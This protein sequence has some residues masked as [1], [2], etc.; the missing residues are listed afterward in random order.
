M[1]QRC[2]QEIQEKTAI[3]SIGVTCNGG[4]NEFFRLTLSYDQCRNHAVVWISRYWYK[5]TCM[6]IPPLP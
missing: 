6:F 1:N 5:N 2:C 4:F 3:L